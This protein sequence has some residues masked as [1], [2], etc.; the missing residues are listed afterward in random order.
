M[1]SIKIRNLTSATEPEVVSGNFIAAA[2]DENAGLTK[3]T[4]KVTFAQVVAGGLKDGV[5]P[6]PIESLPVATNNSLGVVQIGGNLSITPQGVLS[7]N[8]YSLPI[9][10]GT[11]LGGIK[12]GS[13]LSIT[14]QGVLSANSYSLPIASGTVLGG[15]KVGSNLS[16]TPQGVLSANSYSLPIAS[17]TV[18]GGIKVGS[19]LSITPQGVLSANSYSLPIATKQA[20]GGV[21]VGSNL[22]ITPEGLLSVD[23]ATLLPSLPIA[24]ANSLGV[25]QVGANLSITAG[26]VLSA[27]APAAAYQL[28]TASATILGGVKVG[29]NLT[30]DPDG[31]LNANASSGGTLYAFSSGIITNEGQHTITYP[32]G[33]TGGTPDKIIVSTRYPA[34]DANSTVYFQLVSFT[35]T[36]VTV[37]AQAGASAFATHFCDVLLVKNSAS[38]GAQAPQPT[39]PAQGIVHFSSKIISNAST[40]TESKAFEDDA[41]SDITAAGVYEIQSTY[42]FELYDLAIPQGVYRYTKLDPDRTGDGWNGSSGLGKAVPTVAKQDLKSMAIPAGTTVKFSL[43]WTHLGAT[44]AHHDYTRED[45]I[46]FEI[47]GPALI[48]DLSPG[49]TL[50]DASAGTH[51]ADMGITLEK[52][53]NWYDILEYPAAGQNESPRTIFNRGTTSEQ[54]ADIREPCYK[55]TRVNNLYL[56]EPGAKNAVGRWGEVVGSEQFVDGIYDM[57]IDS[58]FKLPATTANGVAIDQRTLRNMPYTSTLIIE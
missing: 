45:L 33:W 50:P 7:A 22:S 52:L 46:F 57:S 11:V 3:S 17:G 5:V 18:L 47:T 55:S 39:P 21:Q 27:P 41:F 56:N 8:S 31:T 24:T 30:I 4:R 23:L 19:N 26:G 28:P 49:E 40:N 44:Y 16:I 53:Y 37:F 12:V 36:T 54:D 1:P 48:V 58:L 43:D 34:G 20:V 51:L 42:A 15:I 29:N 38:G 32:A 35:S 14:P 2:L 25:V 6:I 9:A 10:S 13:N